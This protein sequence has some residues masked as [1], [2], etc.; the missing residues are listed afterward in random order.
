MDRCLA[1][2][3]SRLK[4]RCW[5]KSGVFFFNLKKDGNKNR[6]LDVLLDRARPLNTPIRVIYSLLKGVTINISERRL[7]LYVQTCPAFGEGG[8][9]SDFYYN[10][11]VK[12]AVLG[13]EKEKQQKNF[14]N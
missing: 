3:L 12:N 11:G 14:K 10:E 5:Q 8:V 7:A 6:L 13:V 4:P 2:F 1:L 9:F